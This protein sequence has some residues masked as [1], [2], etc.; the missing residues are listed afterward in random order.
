[1]NIFSETNSIV[2]ERVVVVVKMSRGKSVN[3]R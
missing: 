3:F 2:T 1:M